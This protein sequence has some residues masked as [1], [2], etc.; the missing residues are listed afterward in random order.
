MSDDHRHNTDHVDGTIRAECPNI[1][2]DPD[3]HLSITVQYE[4]VVD[5]TIFEEVMDTWPEC[6]EC[7]AELE[8]IHQQEPSE[9]LTDGGQ[10]DWTDDHCAYCRDCGWY[11]T[12]D[13]HEH[14]SVNADAEAHVTFNPE[15]TVR[16]GVTESIREEAELRLIESRTDRDGGE[17]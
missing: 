12:P 1:E 11:A 7:G 3:K 10:S 4:D 16:Q 6:G 2:D 15:H 9:V 13:S 17:R 14:A 5:T 8:T